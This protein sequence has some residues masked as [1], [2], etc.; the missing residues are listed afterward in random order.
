MFTVYPRICMRI[1]DGYV[2]NTTQRG[3]SFMSL[4]SREEGDY[5]YRA[6]DYSKS[7]LPGEWGQGGGHCALLVN[8]HTYASSE[9]NREINSQEFAWVKSPKR[10][11]WLIL[12]T[13][14]FIVK[15]PLKAA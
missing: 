12:S 5:G 15:K 7:P 8:V 13:K 2:H 9:V 14:E 1:L 10:V 6:Q 11:V 3:A 4:A